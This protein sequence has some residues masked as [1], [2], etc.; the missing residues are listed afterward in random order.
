M[1]SIAYPLHLL[2]RQRALL[3]RPLH[4]Q[5]L[6]HTLNQPH[7][8]P[9]LRLILRS[10]PSSFRRQMDRDHLLASTT[11]NRDFSHHGRKTDHQRSTVL[12]GSETVDR[13]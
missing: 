13:E 5:H 3:R 1:N 7:G 9:T 11:R 6:P 4:S 2:R 12:E 8:S 10:D